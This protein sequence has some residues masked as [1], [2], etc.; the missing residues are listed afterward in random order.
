MLEKDLT[1]AAKALAHFAARWRDWD[2]LETL[3]GLPDGAIEI[4]VLQAEA[5]H[6]ATGAVRLRLPEAL[7]ADLFERLARKGIDPAAVR[8]AGLSLRMDTAAIR[9]DRARIVHFDFGL[10]ARVD[11]GEGERRAS[12]REEHVWHARE[13]G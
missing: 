12:Q 3:A 4:D 6:A 10:E 13:R 1:Q 5:R 11:A 7:R 2:D 9:T 8:A